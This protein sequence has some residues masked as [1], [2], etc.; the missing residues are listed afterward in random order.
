MFLTPPRGIKSGT[1][2]AVLSA[3]VFFLTAGLCGGG[4]ANPCEMD[5]IG[6]HDNAFDFN[7][8]ES[9]TLTGDLDVEV[10]QGEYGFVSFLADEAPESHSGMQGGAHVFLSVRVFNAALDVYDKLRVHL[11]IFDVCEI[12][13]VCRSVHG[14][15]GGR[16]DETHAETESGVCEAVTVERLLVLGSAE[17]LKVSGD[18]SVE[19]SGFVMVMNGGAYEWGVVRLFIEDPCRRSGAH[20]H[21]YGSPAQ[22]TSLE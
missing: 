19:E 8:D 13:E 6:C 11:A 12:G 5:A 2:L 7:Y 10:G 16:C 3:G 17:P 22:D 14:L 21:R 15:D 1:Y 9:C 18:G 4:V 20:E